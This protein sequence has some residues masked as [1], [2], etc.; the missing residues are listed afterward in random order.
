MHRITLIPYVLI[1]GL[2]LVACSHDDR[3]PDLGLPSLPPDT[4]SPEGS[5]GNTL[6]DPRAVALEF[7]TC[8]RTNGVEDYPDPVFSD[9]GELRFRIDDKDDPDLQAASDECLPLLNSVPGFGKTT[10]P[11]AI[12]A[13]QQ[14]GL[15]FAKCMRAEG[16]DVPDPVA[17]G[18]P[19][20]T[21]DPALTDSAAFADATTTC[22]DSISTLSTAP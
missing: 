4:A 13:A 11:A 19:A 18:A 21:L 22:A 8:M 15:A 1:V 16:F 3:T 14:R 17:D 20:V 2:V 12:A 6:P 7:A 9:T 5:A 10:D